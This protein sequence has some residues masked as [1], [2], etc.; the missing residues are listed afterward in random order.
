VLGRR[1]NR[2]GPD[3]QAGGGGRRIAANGLA[4][5]RRAAPGKCCKRGTTQEGLAVG[6]ASTAT[7]LDRLFRWCWPEIGLVGSD[8]PRFPTPTID[9]AGKRLMKN[10]FPDAPNRESDDFGKAVQR[11]P[12]SATFL[13]HRCAWP[14]SAARQEAL[15]LFNKPASPRR[16]PLSAY[17]RKTSIP[18]SGELVGQFLPQ[19]YS[20]VGLIL[21][22]MP[23]VRAVG[24]KDYGTPHNRLESGV[25]IPKSP[26]VPQRGG[27]CS[28]AARPP[29]TG[30]RCWFG[31][32]R[33]THRRALSVAGRWSRHAG[34]HLCHGRPDGR[35]A[36]R[37]LCRF[38]QRVRCWPLLHFSAS[39]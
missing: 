19:T 2:L 14:A 5:R 7:C 11:L 22:A 10:G 38:R 37:L 9:V 34:V 15:E 35:G 27:P 25:P 30:A 23:P 8:D 6:R 21:S 3:R 32:E 13:V 24:R 39:A 16:N 36:S 33:P 20:Q 1:S 31:L 18:V 26:A 29:D 28:G 12:C 17:C 4:R